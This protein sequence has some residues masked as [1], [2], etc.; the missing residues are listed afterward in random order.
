MLTV[1][2]GQAPAADRRPRRPPTAVADRNVQP[3]RR[4][5][6]LGRQHEAGHREL[7]GM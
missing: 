4:A 7:D 1:T 6:A 3:R 2:A 5:S